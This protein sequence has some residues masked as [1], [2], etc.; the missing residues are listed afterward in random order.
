VRHRRAQQL[1]SLGESKRREEEDNGFRSAGR[2]LHP[3]CMAVFFAM[4]WVP[5]LGLSGLR[6]LDGGVGW[7]RSG[8]GRMAPDTVRH[9]GTKA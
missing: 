4:L 3:V 8:I 7:V 9:P 6:A 1:L 2:N 5:L